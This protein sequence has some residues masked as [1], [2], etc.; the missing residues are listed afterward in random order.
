MIEHINNEASKSSLIYKIKDLPEGDYTVTIER[1]KKKRT[2][3][4]NACLHLWCESVAIAFN[5]GGVTKKEVFNKLK[6]GLE[7]P[8][9]KESV[10]ED[11]FKPIM[12]VLLNKESTTELETTEAEYVVE[13]INYNLLKERFNGM[14]VEWPSEED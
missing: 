10:K 3:T 8:W 9:T 5:I 11:I 2:Q 1:K 14:R 13:M 12:K 6:D 4:E 7:I